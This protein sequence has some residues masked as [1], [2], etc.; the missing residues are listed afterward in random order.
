MQEG[1]SGENNGFSETGDLVELNVEA[2]TAL[3]VVSKIHRD[4]TWGESNKLVLHQVSSNNFVDIASWLGGVGTVFS[5]NGLTATVN[6][7]STVTISGTNES[8]STTGI[9]DKYNWSGDESAKVYPAGTYRVPQGF[10]M[11]VRSAQYPNNV[12]ISGIGNL[13][14][15][16]TIPEPFRII[17]VRYGVDAGKTVDVT[18]PIGLFRG[19]TVPDTGY[20]YSGNIYIVEFDTSVYDGEFNWRTGELR[21]SDGNTVAYYDVPEIKSLPGTNYF[22]T[23]F[24][25]NTVSNAPS[26]LSKVIIGLNEPAPEETVSSICDFMFTPTTPEAAYALFSSSFVP[27]GQFHGNEVPV[28]TTKGNLYVKDADGNVKYSKYIDPMFNSRGV[29]DVLTHNGLE[30]NWSKKFYLTKDPISVTE[31]PPPYPGPP[32]AYIFVWEFDENDF[33]NTGIPAKIRDIP[34]VSPCF[35]NNEKS[36][37][38]VNTLGIWNGEPY[39]AFFSYNAETGKYTLAVRGLQAWCISD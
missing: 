27:S 4:E 26:N 9:I 23:C 36:E 28:M 13:T 2:E 35:V 18:L 20:E 8:D 31:S 7:D 25:E 24:G 22:W 32:Q 3:E 19:N 17:W 1:I 16:V 30:K 37:N 10:T 12:A 33:V 15:T 34:I 21:D 29:R 14:D 11:A 6:A 5:K 38:N 39:P